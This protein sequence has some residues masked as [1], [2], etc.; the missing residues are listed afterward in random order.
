[1]AQ[2]NLALMYREGEGTERDYGQACAWLQKATLQGYVFSP[3]VLIR[4]QDGGL[5]PALAE[6]TPVTVVC[7]T[8]ASSVKYNN[9]K[10][11]VVAA[12]PAGKVGRAAVLL[13]EGG[14]KPISFKLMNLRV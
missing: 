8:S 9:M 11:I 1:M 6:G 4:L 12:P 2:H 13:L 7:L 14:S 10:G 3:G 5:L